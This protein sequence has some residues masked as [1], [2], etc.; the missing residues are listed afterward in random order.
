[1]QI[2]RGK[3]H[4]L[5]ERRMEEMLREL[6]WKLELREEHCLWNE[7]SVIR[8]KD[9]GK[10]GGGPPSAS[11][12]LTKLTLER[13]CAYCKGKHAH[14]DCMNVTSAEERRKLL[15]KYS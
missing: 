10:F 7:R 12:L 6:L 14:E 4:K 3:N 11:A 5:K 1:M 8:K 15:S 13:L 9:L 2:T